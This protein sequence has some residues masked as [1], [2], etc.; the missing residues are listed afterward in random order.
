[1]RHDRC[2]TVAKQYGIATGVRLDH[3]GYVQ[4]DG[5]AITLPVQDSILNKFYPLA[6]IAMPSWATLGLAIPRT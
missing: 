2:A 5:L 4:A 1:L 3:L 6:G